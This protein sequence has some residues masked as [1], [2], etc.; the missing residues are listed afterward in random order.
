[1]HRGAA[2][3]DGMFRVVAGAL[4]SPGVVTRSGTHWTCRIPAAMVP[5]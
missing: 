1:M 3:F 5:P 4:L 2:E